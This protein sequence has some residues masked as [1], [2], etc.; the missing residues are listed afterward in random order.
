MPNVPA[1]RTWHP[2]YVAAGYLT[3]LGAAYFDSMRGPL[4]PVLVQEL[5]VPYRLASWFLTAGNIAALFFLALMNP[6]FRL[7]GEKRVGVAA[8]LLATVAGIVAPFV[9][10]FVSLLILGVVIGGSIAV[11]GALCNIYTLRG[12]PDPWKSRML[13]GNHVMYGIG[14]FGA[15]L[16]VAAAIAHHTPWHWLVGLGATFFFVIGVIIA[17]KV[18]TL[19]FE[20]LAE[21]HHDATD[22]GFQALVVALLTAYV[23]GEVMACM[24][25][26]TFLTEARGFT[27][28]HASDVLSGVYLVMALT[29][30]AC[31]LFIRQSWEHGV[32][33]ASLTVAMIAYLLGR[34]GSTWA[35]IAMG[36]FGPFFPLLLARVSRQV[37][38]LWRSLTVK[39]M[40]AIQLSL[41]IFHTVVGQLTD[42]LGIALAYS[43]P[44]VIFGLVLILL[45][46]YFRWEKHFER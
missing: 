25:L 19:P 22:R 45:T 7:I 28:I 41:A 9:D 35:F 20:T 11:V 46:I 3:L 12:S 32:L 2:S 34:V 39:V 43:L 6:A 23:V 24:W 26:V 1:A 13:A 29:R 31:F 40:I 4:V 8:C 10:G 44:P 38:G 33:F 5:G 21:T 27:V 30:L 37:P 17:R 18:P 36:A 14:S 42:R 15:P 16:I